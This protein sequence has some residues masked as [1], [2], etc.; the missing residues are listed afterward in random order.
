MMQPHTLKSRSSITIDVEDGLNILMKDH[1]N[2]SIPPTDRVVKNVDILLDLFLKHD[3]RATFFI[4]GE[5]ADAFPGLI[6]KIDSCGHEIGVHGY[7][8]DQLFKLTP[9]KFACDIKKTKAMLEDITGKTVFGYRAPAFSIT[10]ET[11]WALEIIAE[12][13]FKYDSSIMPAQMKRYGWKGFEKDIVRLDLPGK[14]S[15]IEVPLP[16]INLL[17]NP[18]PACGG[19]YL[20]YFPLGFTKWAFSSIVRNRP[21][22][23]YLHPYELDTTNYPDFFYEA[24]KTLKIRKALPL[25]IYR[26]GKGTVKGKLDSLLRKHK[27]IPLTEIIGCL[28]NENAIHAVELNRFTAV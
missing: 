11:S 6:R 7:I 18:V 20:R 21:V 25:L 5:I 13:G 14:T 17:G 4:L 23:M 10:Q 24:R 16:V 28:E 1:F 8:H 19:G 22:I 15:L 27:F 3:T 26:L 12:A 9:E 2:I